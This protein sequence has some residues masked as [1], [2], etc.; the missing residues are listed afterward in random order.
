LDKQLYDIEVYY[1][2]FCVGLKTLN[3]DGRIFYEIS[4]ERNDLDSIYEYFNS[5]KGFLI[6]FN[7]IHYDNVVIKYILK[8]YYNLR[9]L[10]V[11]QINHNLKVFSDKIIHDDFDEEI[12]SVKYFKTGWI[13]I[14]LYNFWSKMLRISKKISLKSLGIQLGYNVVQELP[15]KPDT[16]LKK[17]DLPKLRNYKFN[18]I[19]IFSIVSIQSFSNYKFI[20]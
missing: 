5:Y 2:F 4:E 12:K 20:Y 15:Y 1:N 16:I 14:D 10:S 6:S 7:G 11:H 13:D 8:N 9:K 17:D 3:K 18:N 19:Y